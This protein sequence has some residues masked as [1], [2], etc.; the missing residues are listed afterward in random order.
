MPEY[1]KSNR[2]E[3]IKSYMIFTEGQ[4]IQK[5]FNV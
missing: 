5:C 3:K 4:S 1:T 2:T